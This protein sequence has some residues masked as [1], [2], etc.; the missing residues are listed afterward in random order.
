MGVKKMRVID[1]ADPEARAFALDRFALVQ[2]HGETDGFQEGDFFYEIVISKNRIA[3]L[4]DM[5][6]QTP[7]QLQRG[8]VFT[9]NLVVVVA[10]QDGHIV[11]QLVD[12]LDNDV[13]QLRIEIAVKV[14]ELHQTK[15][16]EWRG[17]LG[18]EDLVVHDLDV[19]KVSFADLIEPGKLEGVPD[20]LIHRDDALKFEK[21]LSLVDFPRPQAR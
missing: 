1:A 8:I 4:S 17:Q 9:R 19:Q 13:N 10:R 12:S 6:H 15:A 3:R 2:Q 7:H 20:K 21:T 14:G 5:R 18:Q 16:V 11:F